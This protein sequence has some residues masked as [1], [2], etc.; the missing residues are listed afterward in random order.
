MTRFSA[1]NRSTA[2]LDAPSHQVW[3]TLTDPET[4]VRLT[5]YLQAID[6]DGD[7]WT[8]HLSGL[9][10]P[11]SVVSPLFTEVMTLEP[12]RRIGFVHDES[13]PQEQAGVEGE[14]RIHPAGARTDVA[15][16]IAI[17]VDL[18]LPRLARPAVEGVMST[19]VAGM[20]LKFGQNLRRHLASG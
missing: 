7:R 8:W 1:R 11:G 3:A 16:D 5:P 13:R 6:V 17:W 2:T 15:I 4:L 12:E 14:Y 19:V 18:P 9:P 10:V 20:G